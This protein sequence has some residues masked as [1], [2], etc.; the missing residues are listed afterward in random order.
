MKTISQIKA[1]EQEKL[2]VLLKECHVFFAFSTEQFNENKT[3]KQPDEKYVHC[4][5]G[6]Y[7]PRSF[8][9]SFESGFSDLNKWYKS[10][11]K[12]SKLWEKEIAYELNNHECYYTGDISP[13]VEMFAGTYTKKQILDVYRKNYAREMEAQC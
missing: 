5:A 9:A 7:M 1:E 8:V 2:S 4:G 12:K 6:M 11:V 10:E 13:V 3:E